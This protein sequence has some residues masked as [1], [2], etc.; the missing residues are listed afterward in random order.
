MAALQSVRHFLLQA[1]VLVAFDRI[2]LL[3]RLLIYADP[4]IQMC[5]DDE[6]R[7]GNPRCGEYRFLRPAVADVQTRNGIEQHPDCQDQV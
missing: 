6:Q 4:V 3:L 1:P 7:D 2:Q 5:S